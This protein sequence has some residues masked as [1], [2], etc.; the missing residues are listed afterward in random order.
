MLTAVE[1]TFNISWLYTRFIYFQKWR[2]IW[3]KCCETNPNWGETV[4]NFAKQTGRGGGGGNQLCAKARHATSPGHQA[5]IYGILDIFIWTIHLISKSFCTWV[6]N[7]CGLIHKLPVVKTAFWKMM[8]GQ[9]IDLIYVW[10]SPKPRYPLNQFS[11]SRNWAGN[12]EICI[13]D[14]LLCRA[15]LSI[16]VFQ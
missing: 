2:A 9:W 8:N 10:K 11:K 6:K 12:N 13:A 5:H 16:L 14:N 7:N 4:R 1:E 15:S 3:T